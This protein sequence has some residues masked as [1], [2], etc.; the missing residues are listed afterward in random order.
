MRLT[1][2]VYGI[3]TQTKNKT[4]NVYSYLNSA[5]CTKG[6]VGMYHADLTTYNKALVHD[7]FKRGIMR[8]LVA[9][10]AYGM[11]DCMIDPYPLFK[12]IITFV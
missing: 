12:D 3:F 5:S 7:Q 1:T 2:R 8:I 10:V 11:V 6:A 4:C 9:T